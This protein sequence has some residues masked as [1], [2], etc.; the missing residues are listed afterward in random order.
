MLTDRFVD[1]IVFKYKES[2]LDMDISEFPASQDSDVIGI[3]I[4]YSESGSTLTVV[5][6]WVTRI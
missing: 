4:L 6:C 5:S 3:Y 1:W 2:N